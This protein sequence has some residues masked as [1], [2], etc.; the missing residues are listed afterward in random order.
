MLEK[1]F[2]ATIVAAC[3]VLL[4][5]VF[6][7]P[8][9]RARFDAAIARWSRRTG[10]RVDAVFA[11]PSARRRARREAEAAIRRAR[12]GGTWDGNVYRPKSFKKDRRI[13]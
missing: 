1:I 10:A 9:R 5:R 3:L 6:L 12:D 8:R 4:L 11:W 13:H 7:G 2:A